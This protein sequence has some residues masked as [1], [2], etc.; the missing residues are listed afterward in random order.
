[1]KKVATIVVGLL[2][3]L[4]A[5]AQTL[6]VT[7]GSVTYQFPA[8]QTGDMTYSG[9]TSLTIMGKTFALS[10]ISS[11]SVDNTEVTNNLVAIAYNGTSATVTVAG[12]IAQY[13]EPTVSGA[14]VSIAQSNT[15]AVDNDEITYQLSGTSTDG[16]LDLSG[17]YKCTVS[18]AGV[19]LTCA[20]G[21]AINIT[22]KKRIQISAKNGTTNTL[23]DCSGGS[24]KGCIYSKGQIQLQ[25]NGTLTVVGKTKHAIKSGDY[26]AVKNLTLN[27]T[28][29]VGDGISSNKYFLMESGTVTISGVSD[30]GIQCDLET[31]D[32][33]TAETTNHEDENSGNVY[34]EG[35][36]LTV[37]VTGQATKG[38]KSAGAMKISGGTIK[39]TTSG[40]GY[41]DSTERDAKGCAGLKS[42]G[43]MTISGGTITLTSSGTGGKCIK[44]D[45]ALTISGGTINATS[46]GSNYKYSSY[47]TASAKA[48]KSDGALVITN[49]T[50]VAKA[51]SHEA[52]ESKST[53]TI[54]G[55]DIYAQS[56]DDA[57][58]SA[59]TF[60]I[61]GGKVMGYSTGN[62]GLD[63]NGNFIIEGGVVYAIGARSPEMA[64]DANTEGGYKL[65]VKGGIIFTCGPLEGGSTLTQA[66][67]STTSINKNVW[68]S[69]TNGS[70]TYC[71]KTP[72]SL[73]VST[74]VVS[75]SSKPTVK[76][77]VTVSGGTTMMN[78]MGYA[79]ATV[80]GGSEVS[81]STYS[82]GSGGG[83]GGG[84]GPWW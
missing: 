67:Y 47:Y 11:M 40:N 74:L 44:C 84:H 35:G 72:S 16:Q 3:T 14:Y 1:M 54:S 17:S 58:N 49:G 13:V 28:G 41:Y 27:V 5:A 38:V 22:N 80:S 56:S 24:Q 78:G 59:S 15:D 21:S 19:N 51:S 62:D 43:A 26:I 52:I 50:I 61:S 29:A 83:G 6:N 7:V 55:G 68:Y 48:I 39:V 75:A 42:D 53:I 33:Q 36:T 34:L 9:G 23:T 63:A 73:S 18:L 76:S 77:G 60:T 81:L 37:T 82:S 57:I 31:D 65:T 70:E 20:T 8:A 32:A 12:N 2:T 10:D 66:C 30:D 25:G 45:G 71:F 69:L 4:T 64:I 46:T 79:S